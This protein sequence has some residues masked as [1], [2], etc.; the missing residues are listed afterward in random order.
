MTDTVDLT[1]L[2]VAIGQGE[3]N[4]FDRLVP[5]VYPDLRRLARAQLRRLRVGETL[6]TTALVHEAYVKLVDAERA[7]WND[8]QH[9]LAVASVAM[10][11]ILV[12]HA[13]ARLRAK[14]GGG[15]ATVPLDEVPGI[16]AR[17]AHD[18]VE[19]DEAL[20]RL[21]AVDPRLVRVVECRY[22]TGLSEQET[23]DALGVSLRT[24]QRDWLKARAWLRAALRP[25]S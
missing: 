15:A 13:R 25:G 22:F 11:Q 4:A 5:L 16:V 20:R 23:A 19:L 3:A 9:F 6:D 10:R 8:R 12:D 21:E 1:A 18:L 14:R 7:N 17:E 24:A 2:L